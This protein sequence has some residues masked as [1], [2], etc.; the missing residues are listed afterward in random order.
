VGIDCEMV[1][2]EGNRS[3]LARASIVNY[4]GIVIYDK[5]VRP[6]DRITDYRTWVSGIYANDLKVENGAI[7]EN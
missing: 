7:P 6:N 5:Y 3:S 4:N 1:G 2:T